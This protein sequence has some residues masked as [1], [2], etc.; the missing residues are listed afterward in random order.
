VIEDELEKL[1]GLIDD[2]AKDGKGR[3]RKG[4]RDH[5]VDIIDEEE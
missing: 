5:G 4:L 3:N 2:M 1:E